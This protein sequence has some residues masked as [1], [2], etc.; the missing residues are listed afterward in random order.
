[1]GTANF[2]VEMLQGNV[3]GFIVPALIFLSAAA[4]SFATGSSWGTFAIM[5]PLAIPIA[6]GLDAPMLVCI[7]A[8]LSGGI[9]G[10]HCSPIS[11]STILASTG[12]GSDHI[13][14]VKTQIPYAVT[15]GTIVLFMFII[16][17]ITASPYTVLIGIAVMITTF[18]T[19][20]R[21]T[22]RRE[23]ASGDL[24][25][26]ESAAETVSSNDDDVAAR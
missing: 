11:D 18:I 4:M 3:P 14:H 23:L 5:I 12:A 15:N 24:V 26:V 1:M 21:L 22:R 6:I 7:G 20:A 8:V 10:D 16:A 2:I 17:G 9:F 19:I 13:D 25:S